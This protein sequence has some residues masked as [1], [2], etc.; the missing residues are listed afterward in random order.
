MGKKNLLK[1]IAIG[2]LS[3]LFGG[4]I[5]LKGYFDPTF[6]RYNIIHPINSSNTGLVEIKKDNSDIYA[7]LINSGKND[8]WHDFVGDIDSVYHTLR[9]SGVGSDNIYIIDPLN[10]NRKGNNFPAEKKGL[11]SSIKELSSKINQQDHFILYLTNHGGKSKKDPNAEAYITFDNGD[12]IKESEL[13]EKVSMINPKNSLLVFTPCYSDAFAKRLGKGNV[14]TIANTTSD[15]VAICYGIAPL[16]NNFFPKLFDPSQYSKD[17]DLNNDG[18]ISVE[19]AFI[20]T[21]N[22]DWFSNPLSPW[23]NVYQLRYE[24]INPSTFSYVDQKR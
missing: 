19:E 7:L 18:K 23:R 16:A 22:S 4:Y 13:E 11:D 20:D 14:I 3:T 21:A 9:N 8:F 1:K 6:N 12:T 5:L 15:K 24:K 2:T 10:P 17:I